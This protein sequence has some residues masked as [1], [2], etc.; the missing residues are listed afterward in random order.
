MDKRES[1]QVDFGPIDN[2]VLLEVTN[3]VIDGDCD[4]EF[5]EIDREAENGV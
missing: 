3:I 5:N 4:I 1:K 2:G